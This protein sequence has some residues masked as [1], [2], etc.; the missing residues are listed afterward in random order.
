MNDQTNTSTMHDSKIDLAQAFPIRTHALN[1]ADHALIQQAREVTAKEL[2]ARDLLEGSSEEPPEAGSL[3]NEACSD[4]RGMARVT[5]VT[6]DGWF[7]RQIAFSVW[8]GSGLPL[9]D[10]P[11]AWSEYAAGRDVMAMLNDPARFLP[12]TTPDQPPAS[13]H[14]VD[15]SKL[16]HLMERTLKVLDAFDK[17]GDEWC[18][19]VDIPADIEAE[20]MRLW[21]VMNDLRTKALSMP[22]HTPEGL[23]AKARLVMTTL[24][25]SL[26]GTLAPENSDY[27]AFALC[28]DLIGGEERPARSPEVSS[29]F[30]AYELACRRTT[31]FDDASAAQERSIE[32]KG[33]EKTAANQKEEVANQLGNAL[34]EL[35]PF[36]QCETI[37]DVGA[38]VGVALDFLQSV[39]CSDDVDQGR[40]RSA[41]VALIGTLPTL[42]RNAERDLKRVIDPVFFNEALATRDGVRAL[43]GGHA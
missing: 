22:A 1:A 19:A 24:P 33:K 43:M 20:Q 18:H 5:P 21:D 15:D 3:F 41:Y 29:A 25:L 38:Q 13:P 17:L 30:H 23:K 9:S 32:T 6:W 7:A 14:E 36:A 26:D 16:L 37:S 10:C 8:N 4:V 39:I 31:A 27:P 28:R 42:L 11:T 40:L 2:R 35:V 34:A 12:D